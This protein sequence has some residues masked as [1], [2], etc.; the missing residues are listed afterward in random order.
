M[1]SRQDKFDTG[2]IRFS[3]KQMIHESTFYWKNEYLRVRTVS[4]VVVFS[5][6]PVHLPIYSSLSGMRSPSG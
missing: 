2:W 6:Y 1:L 5:V 4:S 3:G